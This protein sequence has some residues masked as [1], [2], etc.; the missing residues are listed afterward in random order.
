LKTAAPFITRC[1]PRAL[2]FFLMAEKKSIKT[3]F[4]AFDILSREPPA[5]II[6]RIFLRE[7]TSK[8][9]SSFIGPIEKDAIFSHQ[10]VST[11]E[12]R[13]TLT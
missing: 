4:K 10:P 9:L 13:S 3:H 12:Y 8:R 6:P 7:A 1:P 2:L 11:G 5:I